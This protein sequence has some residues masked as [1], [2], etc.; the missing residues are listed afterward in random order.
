MSQ[1]TLILSAGSLIGR[2]E[3][4]GLFLCIALSNYTNAFNAFALHNEYSSRYFPIRTESRE[5]NG[6]EQSTLIL[7]WGKWQWKKTGCVSQPCSTWTLNKWPTKERI[8]E[9]KKRLHPKFMAFAINVDRIQCVLI[10]CQI[11]WSFSLLIF[12]KF[13]MRLWAQI[14]IKL[15]V[16]YTKCALLPLLLPLNNNRSLFTF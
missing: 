13:W 6:I 3:F 1:W 8:D 7:S 12:F 2:D 15:C 5:W 4:I 9:K 10:S 14:Y 16:Q 11:I